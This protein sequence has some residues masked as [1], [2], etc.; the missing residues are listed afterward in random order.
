MN[1][2]LNYNNRR[3]ITHLVQLKKPL[4]VLALASGAAHQQVA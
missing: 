4:D 2:S 1:I 3:D